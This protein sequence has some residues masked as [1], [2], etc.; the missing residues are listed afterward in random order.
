M[1]YDDE[2]VLQAMA[3]VVGTPVKVDQNTFK[4]AWGKFARV[5]VDI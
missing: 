2:N 4:V 3:S 1:A 5:Y